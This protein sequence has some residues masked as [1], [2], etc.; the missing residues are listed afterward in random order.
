[1]TSP[2]FLI[3]APKRLD[4]PQMRRSHSAAI[5]SPPPTQMPW[6]WA[7]SGWRQSASACAVVCMTLP[8]SIACALFARIVANSPMSL[9]G[10]NAFSPAPR[11]ITQRRL[12]SADSAPISSPSARHIAFVSALSFSGRLRTT[13]A[14]APSRS[15]RTRSAMP[16]LTIEEFDEAHPGD[17]HVRDEQQY[18]QQDT[19]EPHIDASDV[20]DRLLGNRAR[21]HQHARDRRSLL[22]DAEV[23]GYDQAEMHGV[24]AHGPDQRHHHRHHQDDRRRRMQEHPEQ[25]EE[26]IEECQHQPL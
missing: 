22:A 12:S 16:V 1:M 5:S 6:I 9:P 13:V 20:P 2:R 24:D 4:S 19:D 14:I 8:Y 21:D 17:R 15:I 11:M 3:G 23:D 10:E 18:R 26:Q 25:Q 7:T